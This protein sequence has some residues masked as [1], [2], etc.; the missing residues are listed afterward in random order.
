MPQ[1]K[2]CG[3]K[4]LFL[5]IEEDTGLCL[6]CGRDF[7]EKAK[8]L[9]EK[10]IEAK[11]RVRT[12]KDSKDISSLCEAIERNGNELVLLHRDY[13]L[14]PSQELLD[15]IETYKKMGELAEK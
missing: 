6:S 1:C 14:E 13:N 11:N 9:T 12:T 3:K 4:G 7:A 10:I 8:V 15:L 2:K 5:K